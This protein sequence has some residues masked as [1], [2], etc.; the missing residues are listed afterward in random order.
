[1]SEIS[2]IIRFSPIPKAQEFKIF[3]DFSYANKNN[4]I[5]VQII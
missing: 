2:C 5:H 4:I 3:K 1:M